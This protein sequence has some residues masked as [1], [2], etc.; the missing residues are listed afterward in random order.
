MSATDL[1]R[2]HEPKMTTPEAGTDAKFSMK[3]QLNASMSIAP[4]SQDEYEQKLHNLG[5]EE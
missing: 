2:S 1:E 5:G 4:Q 3:Q